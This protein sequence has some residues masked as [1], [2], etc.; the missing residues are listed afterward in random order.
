MED[1]KVGLKK[2]MI[3]DHMYAKVS[4]LDP[5]LTPSNFGIGT[6]FKPRRRIFADRVVKDYN[7]FQVIFF[8][9]LNALC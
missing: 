2:A 3:S 1:P 7:E 4:L 9:T 5:N 6:S 8:Q